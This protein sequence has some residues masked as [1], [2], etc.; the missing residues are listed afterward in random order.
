[1]RGFLRTM[2]L[3]P[4]VFLADPTAYSEGLSETWRVECAAGLR[5]LQERMQTESFE[6]HEERLLANGKLVKLRLGVSR[7]QESMAYEEEFF[8]DYAL[9]KLAGTVEV[10]CLN[11]KK[12]FKLSKPP[13]AARFLIEAIDENTNPKREE[14]GIDQ[15]LMMKMRAFVDSPFSLTGKRLVDLIKNPE[16]Q[17]KTVQEIRENGRARVELLFDASSVRDS[18]L[19]AGRITLD[20][21]F[22]WAICT[23]DASCTLP[24]GKPDAANRFDARI[25]GRLE[26][27]GNHGEP[28]RIK[29]IRQ[30]VYLSKDQQKPTQY[31]DVSVEKYEARRVP[32]TRFDLSNWGLPDVDPRPRR[33][34]YQLALQGWLFWTSLSVA[35]ICFVVLRI[36]GRRGKLAPQSTL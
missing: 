36:L 3:L 14:S 26:Y 24:L 20:P 25:V 30:D 16:F 9:R 1:M 11:P 28:I 8:S 2:W 31:R 4:A 22:D 15:I 18:D 19:K 34:F 5:R 10:Y 27:E 33:S 21:G 32:S 6:A 12:F 7:D 35:L 17:I 29:R 23:Y 13:G